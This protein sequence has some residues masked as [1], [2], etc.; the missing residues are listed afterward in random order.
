M[1]CLGTDR[2]EDRTLAP[3]RLK[4]RLPGGGKRVA[5]AKLAIA[6]TK[7]LVGGVQEQEAVRELMS[8]EALEG[9]IKL[10]LNAC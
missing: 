10:M 8:G 6:T 7:H 9:R 5:T 2:L 1:V 4:H 3:D